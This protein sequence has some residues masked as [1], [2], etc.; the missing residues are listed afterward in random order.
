MLLYI[1]Q[2]WL[3]NL[4]DNFARQAPPFQDYEMLCS[5]FSHNIYKTHDMCIDV[6]FIPKVVHLC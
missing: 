6:H 2:F 4:G 3:K 5:K 1:A